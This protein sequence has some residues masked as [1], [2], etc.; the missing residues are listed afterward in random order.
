MTSPICLVTP[1]YPPATG[2]VEVHCERLASGLAARGLEVEVVTTDPGAPAPWVEESAGVR[3]RRFPTV[4]HDSTYYVAPRLFRWLATHAGDYALL[5]AHSY[6]TPLALAAAYAAWRRQ[7]PLIVSP[8]YHG[9][10]HSAFRAALHRPYRPFGA[11]MLRQADVVVSQS[12]CERQLLES[13]FG[14]LS[15]V[16]VIG[17]G[18][19]LDE[20]SRARPLELPPGKV[21]LLAVGR[22]ESY[23]GTLRI[24]AALRHLD[25]RFVLVVIGDGPER[26]SLLRHAVQGK[27]RHRITILS[28]LPRA[29]LL[30]WLASADVYVSLSAHESFGLAPLEAAAA[31][32]PTVLSDIP[33]HRELAASMAAG[34]ATLIHPHFGDRDVAAVIEAA[35]ASG[36]FS[37]QTW[38]PPTWDRMVDAISGLYGGLT[39]LAIAGPRLK[40]GRVAGTSAQRRGASKHPVGTVE[41]ES[42]QTGD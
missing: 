16:R 20:L 30:R 22:L 1:R 18:V 33:A 13:D 26:A 32:L 42:Q 41:G 14:T 25:P 10:G 34:Q 12:K 5:H 6:H 4:A 24:L 17:S 38:T 8:F 27:I 21:T 39:P 31:G 9:T 15:D 37:T 29:D 19:D 7:T 2:G 36:R 3:I 23:K 28:Q 35:A 40:Q 11:W